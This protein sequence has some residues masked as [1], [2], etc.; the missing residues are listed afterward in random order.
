MTE[1]QGDST[2]FEAMDTAAEKAEQDFKSNP[3]QAD[4]A[5][6]ALIQTAA[7][8][9]A[10]QLRLTHAAHRRMR[11]VAFIGMGVFVSLFLLA[12][13]AALCRLLSLDSLT[14]VLGLSTDYQWHSLVFVSVLIA[15]FAAI[16]L[17][18]AMALVKMISEKED[19]ND[20]ID[21]KTPSTELGKVILDLLKSVINATK[22]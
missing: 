14:V 19:Q 13:L 11:W 21:L 6:G 4:G 20:G 9:H 5:H 12:L 16:P 1:P 18:L 22:N 10:E 2:K 17:S 7:D 3:V 8:A 15:V